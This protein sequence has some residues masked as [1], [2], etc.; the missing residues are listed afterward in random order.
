MGVVKEVLGMFDDSASDCP[1]IVSNSQ[2]LPCSESKLDA[3]PGFSCLVQISSVVIT[4]TYLC[5]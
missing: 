2:L 5:C 1:R 3:M 4:K